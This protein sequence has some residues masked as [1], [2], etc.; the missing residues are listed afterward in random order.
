ML[1]RAIEEAGLP[2]TTIVLIKEHAQ[3][4]KPPRAL[5]VP[6]P[7]GFALGNPEDP[8]F[9]HKVLAATLDLLEAD[10]TPVLAEFPEDGKAPA[11]LVQAAAARAE[12]ASHVDADA[13]GELTAMRGYYERW[14]DDHGGRTMV[15]L[16]GIPQRRWR[17]LVKY[18]ESFA[19]GGEVTYDEMPQDMPLP[20]FI[21][22][23]ADDLK[24]FYMEA[25]MC[26]RP[27][28]QNNELQR[29]FWTETAAGDLI[30]RVADRMNGSE[31]EELQRAAFG[32]AR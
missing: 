32:I 15:G 1:A 31:D 3:R 13:A 19:D 20:R 28:Q 23:A 9:Q 22:L 30:A 17:G 29:W 7:F 24:A 27:D 5:F 10:S 8:P 12:L 14:V 2:T 25:R 16:S 21:R 11:Q 4:V 26:Q 18:L 6:F